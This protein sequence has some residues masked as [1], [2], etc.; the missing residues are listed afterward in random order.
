MDKIRYQD[1]VVHEEAARVLNLDSC[2]N[3][4]ITVCT[5]YRHT[6]REMIRQCFG[7]SCVVIFLNE[8]QARNLS[9]DSTGGGKLA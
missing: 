5:L 6:N 7:D 3:L 4:P 9:L 1:Y 2:T 8:R